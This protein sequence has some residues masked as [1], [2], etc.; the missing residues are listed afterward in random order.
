M[1]QPFSF[2][3]WSRKS[4][5][6]SAK[7]RALMPERLEERRLLTADP[8]VTVDTNFGNFQN[9]LFPA[10]APQTVANFL[11]YVESGAYTNSIFHRSVPNFIVQS[12][13]FT[14]PSAT[15]TSTS[16]SATIP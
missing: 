16:Q 11:N 5:G 8:I 6:R 4:A 7:K 2:P 9:E 15:F 14:S 10:A 1:R 12:G 3:R 13:G